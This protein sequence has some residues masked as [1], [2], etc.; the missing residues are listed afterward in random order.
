MKRESEPYEY[1]EGEFSVCLKSEEVQR[2]SFG[3]SKGGGNV[4]LLLSQSCPTLC[5]I[6]GNSPLGFYTSG[7]HK[8]N[9]AVNVPGRLLAQES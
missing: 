1:L 4:L 8:N 9:T 5:I 3:G 2:P 7:K 6:P